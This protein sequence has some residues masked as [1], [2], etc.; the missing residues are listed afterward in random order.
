M[1]DRPP[2]FIA[3]DGSLPAI[4]DAN[5][6][7][8]FM[9]IPEQGLTGQWA[10]LQDYARA[11]ADDAWVYSCV[12]RLY[13]AAQSVPLRVYVKTKTA[14]ISVPGSPTTPATTMR[15]PAEDTTDVAAQDAQWVLDN[16]NG[17]DGM[18]GADLKAWMMAGTAI[19]GEG[20]IAK[21]RGAR[22][23]PP[24]EL[25]YLRAP[26]IQA[27]A[28]PGPMPTVWQHTP[29]RGPSQTLTW[30]RDVVIFRSPNLED[31]TRGLSP[32]AAVRQDM[33]VNRQAVEQTAATLR[34]WSV[35]VGAWTP[36]GDAKISNTDRRLIQRVFSSLRGPK[37]A[38]KT[39]V[40]PSRLKWQAMAISPKDGEWLAARQV[41]RMTI[42]A[43][44]GVPLVLAG[45]DAKISTYA[46]L[47]DARKIM[48]QDT[49]IPILDWQANVLEG[50]YLS[51]FDNRDP[52]QHRLTL[53]FD[54]SQIEALQEPLEQ[55]MAS[56]V[57]LLT[58]RAVTI[59]QLRAHFRLGAPVPW[60]DEEPLGAS[61]ITLKGDLPPAVIP[62]AG[63][64]AS[65]EPQPDETLEPGGLPEVDVP[66]LGAALRNYGPLLYRHPAVR[67]FLA[68]VAQPLDTET[69]FAARVS[70]P[71]RH[72][73]E[74]GLHRRY[75]AEQISAGVPAEGYPG[76]GLTEGV[77]V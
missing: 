56:W 11:P 19:W 52:R 44:L 20:W 39:A 37:N 9:G 17:H 3:D 10:S 12:R 48:W 61:R 59:N 18:N 64:R 43:A 70:G 60:G 41:S 16:V 8:V 74:I 15:V 75:T 42:C 35:P 1:S 29:S 77:L 45:D 36:E 63:P 76:L 6:W 72:A 25:Y 54:Y 14:A 73:V 50:W 22:G 30:P 49:V 57:A 65:A 51:E 33:E 5:T 26:D 32:I 66:D 2:M 53:A 34:N 31:P 38:G 13:Q 67:A 68:D 24:Q 55:Q 71:V 4:R 7:K 58:A 46:N 62:G 69:L 47:R 27:S 23:G 21:V 28:S 40:V